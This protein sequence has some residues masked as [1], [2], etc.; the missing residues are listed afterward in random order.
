MAALFLSFSFSAGDPDTMVLLF[1]PCLL[2]GT[3]RMTSLTGHHRPLT[4]P[5]SLWTPLHLPQKMKSF[6]VHRNSLGSHAGPSMLFAASF[7]AHACLPDWAS[8]SPFIL[9]CSGWLSSSYLCDQEELHSGLADVI[10][11]LVKNTFFFSPSPAKSWRPPGLK[12]GSGLPEGGHIAQC[13]LMVCKGNPV[14]CRPFLL[15]RRH[16]SRTFPAQVPSLSSAG[17]GCVCV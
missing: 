17:T 1:L 6:R 5:L 4:C 16:M 12:G 8:S 9:L 11:F 3:V 13:G 10:G 7:M 2:F 15:R 14:R